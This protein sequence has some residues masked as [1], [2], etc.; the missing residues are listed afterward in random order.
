MRSIA[1]GAA[2]MKLSGRHV[3]LP[4]AN[5]SVAGLTMLRGAGID[6]PSFGHGD[7]RVTDPISTLLR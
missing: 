6:I 7:G 1:M 2:K 3:R 5:A 4:S